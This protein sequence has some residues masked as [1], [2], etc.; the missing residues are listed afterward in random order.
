MDWVTG[1]LL[2]WGHDRMKL[3][4]HSGYSSESTFARIFQ[5]SVGKPEHKILCADLSGRSWATE[6]K[7]MALAPIYRDALIVKFALPAKD[8]GTLFTEKDMA[9]K[10][11]VPRETFR[12]RV[13]RAKQRI[14]HEI[15]K[16]QKTG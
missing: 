5:G 8:D 16:A 7:V 13:R 4:A 3:Y 2:A 1:M 6:F 10:L 11:G 9:R 14:R 12:T 15:I